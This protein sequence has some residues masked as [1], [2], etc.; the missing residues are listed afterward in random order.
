MQQR[1]KKLSPLLINQICAGEVVTR[2][3]SVVK[4]LLENAIDAGATHIRIDIEQGGLGHIQVSDDGHGIHADDMLLAVTR[5]ATSKIA[6]VAELTGI[7]SLGFRGEALASIAGVSH[8]TLSSSPDNTGIGRQLTVSGNDASHANI[9]PIVKDKGT[10]VSVRDL[11]FNVPARRHHLKSISTEFSHIEQIVQKIAS[12]FANINIE[13]YHQNKLRLNLSTTQNSLV[14]LEISLNKNLQPF[15]HNIEFNL[16]NLSENLDKNAKVLGF[17][18]V[19]QPTLPR[20]IYINHRLV[21]DFSISQ[22]LQKVARQAGFDQIGYALFFELP[23]DWINVN[24]HPSKQQV[25]IQPLSHILAHLSQNMLDKLKNLSQKIEI[26]KNVKNDIQRDK[27]HIFDKHI[28]AKKSDTLRTL[29]VS[30]K[31]ATYQT[32]THHQGNQQNFTHFAN[33]S[34]T[35]ANLLLPL[36]LSVVESVGESSQNAGK[37]LVLHY[38]NA[39]YLL[40]IS[41]QSLLNGVLKKAQNPVEAVN[42]WL[43]GQFLVSGKIEQRLIDDWLKSAKKV[44]YTDLC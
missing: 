23:T 43:T 14:R 30:E 27:T 24:I 42:V 22:T 8:L 33:I 38:A 9:Q 31:N 12:S 41:S 19:N 32:L 39:L 26:N 18:W 7:D 34:E 4:E 28:L 11:Y 25:K 15:A 16:P 36:A 13:L 2:P 6:D 17:F 35:Q 21:T 3:A 10:T 5:H 20:L 40:K 37:T 1:I 44:D 29:K